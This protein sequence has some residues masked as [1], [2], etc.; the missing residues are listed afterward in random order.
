M[1]EI[2]MDSEQERQEYILIRRENLELLCKSQLEAFGRAFF[3]LKIFTHHLQFLV[4]EKKQ[5]SPFPPSSRFFFYYFLLSIAAYIYFLKKS[6]GNSF[7]ISAFNNLCISIAMAAEMIIVAYD[8]DSS[9]LHCFLCELQLYKV[10][11]IEATCCCCFCPTKCLSIFGHFL[12]KKSFV[13]I[14]SLSLSP[15]AFDHGPP[16]KSITLYF[17]SQLLFFGLAGDLN[18]KVI[19]ALFE[20]ERERE[21]EREKLKF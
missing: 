20:R 10:C 4:M 9:S 19:E 16:E 18:K 1:F 13:S 3:S 15:S 2:A 7:E 5:K 21:R 14:F 6:H 17:I 12:K 8:C 11:E